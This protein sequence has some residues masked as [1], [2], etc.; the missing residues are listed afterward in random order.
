MK[1]KYQKKEEF[2]DYYKYWCNIFLQPINRMILSPELRKLYFYEFPLFITPNRMSY[3]NGFGNII[4]SENPRQKIET[5]EPLVEVL[6]SDKTVSITCEL[7]G[8]AKENIKLEITKNIVIIKANN[9]EENY[10]KE[11]KLPCE[12]DADSA[13]ISFNNGVIDL[14]LRKLL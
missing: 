12:V 11:I 3:I 13:I 10:L 9:G 1:K 4:F 14:D 5:K 6:D 2:D 7:P 8:F